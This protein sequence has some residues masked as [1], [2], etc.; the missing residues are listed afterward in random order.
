MD[1]HEVPV[2]GNTVDWLMEVHKRDRSA[3]NMLRQSDKRLVY[4]ALKDSI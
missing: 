1:R 3:I 4:C 2:H